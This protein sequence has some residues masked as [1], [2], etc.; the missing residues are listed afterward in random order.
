M[1]VLYGTLKSDTIYSRRIKCL[2]YIK[3]IMSSLQLFVFKVKIFSL[4]LKSNFQQISLP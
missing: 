4:R 1:F 3:Q 2:V